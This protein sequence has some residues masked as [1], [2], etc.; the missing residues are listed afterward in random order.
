MN[1]DIA[2]LLAKKSR[3]E[4]EKREKRALMLFDYI[5]LCDKKDIASRR[6][7]LNEKVAIQKL[8]IQERSVL[9]SEKRE[10]GEKAIQKARKESLDSKRKKLADIGHAVLKKPTNDKTSAGS[11]SLDNLNRQSKPILP[12]I[13]PQIERSYKSVEYRRQSKELSKYRH[14]QEK[15]HN[16]LLLNRRKA[17]K[18]KPPSEK[19][20]KDA[21]QI[22]A[23]QERESSLKNTPP[24]LYTPQEVEAFLEKYKRPDSPYARR[25]IAKE[26]VQ[27]VRSKVVLT[28]L[29]SMIE[30]DKK[31]KAKTKHLTSGNI[32]QFGFISAIAD[33]FQ[34]GYKHGYSSDDPAWKGN[35]VE[36]KVKPNFISGHAELKLITGD[37][38]E[39]IP[40][41]PPVKEHEQEL[42]LDQEIK[43]IIPEE[44]EEEIKR[45]EKIQEKILQAMD[46]TKLSPDKQAIANKAISLLSTSRRSHYVTKKTEEASPKHSIRTSTKEN[47][48]S[49]PSLPTFNLAILMDDDEPEELNQEESVSSNRFTVASLR[50]SVGERYSVKRLSRVENN[51]DTT[52][53]MSKIDIDRESL[54]DFPNNT[55]RRKSFSMLGSDFRD[56]GSPTHE[57][58][59]SFHR[60]GTGDENRVIEPPEPNPFG[61]G[62][63]LFKPE[64]MEPQPLVDWLDDYP[65]KYERHQKYWHSINLD[66]V[67]EFGKTVYKSPD[68]ANAAE[69]EPATVRPKYV[70]SKLKLFSDQDMDYSVE[71]DGH[72]KLPKVTCGTQFWMAELDEAN[73]EEFP[74]FFS[75]GT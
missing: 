25:I 55:K 5:E 30:T 65:P 52:N 36:E 61:Y 74:G 19:K 75:S 14:R 28:K 37:I 32:N 21:G 47:R 72:C 62:H 70:P 27:T 8:E 57:G 20:I 53:R 1:K 51:R 26:T 22:L 43:E 64:F 6:K 3:E 15:L 49:S 45:E 11:K 68:V 69:V 2:K 29:H 42:D 9:L 10:Q 18:V 35:V 73:G 46:E 31:N 23:Q 16:E 48:L 4:N 59:S 56:P 50:P 67:A 41:S 60:E 17:L 58:H 33:N 34:L 63:I 66:A 40:L 13:T 12:E 71:K 38:A 24:G 54:L 44:T 39:T 7:E